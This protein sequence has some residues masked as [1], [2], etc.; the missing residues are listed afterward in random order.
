[1]RQPV[2]HVLFICT[3][4]SARGLI[5][6]ALMT[7]KSNGSFR[8]FSAGVHPGGLINPFAAELIQQSGYPLER[9]RCKRW[10][11]FSGATAVPVDYIISLCKHAGNFPQPAWPGNPI[12]AAWN[13]EDP[14]STTGSIEE[15][16]G[17]FKRVC[18]QIEEHI[19]LF[20]LLPHNSFDR[21]VL[22]QELNDFHLLCNGGQADG[23]D[24]SRKHAD[25]C[26]D[27][28]VE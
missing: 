10:E 18:Q 6:E 28:A 22:R 13:I 11:E 20:L 14:T 8:G 1:M 4:N 15:K 21:E 2:K 7:V 25:G 23:A 17:V 16:R 12:I 26:K 5:A 3:G 19:E 27:L 9:L 24:Y